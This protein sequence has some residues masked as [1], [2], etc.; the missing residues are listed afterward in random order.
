MT[1][2]LVVTNPSAGTADDDTVAAALD[3]LR[4]GADV[5]VEQSGSP[6]ELDDLLARRDGRT[7]VLLGG[8][9]SLHLAV[10]RLRARGEL[11]P[12]DPLGL[13]PLGTGNDLAR[14]LG[15]PLDP[16]AAAEVLLR[17]RPRTLDLIVDDADGAAVNAVHV[18]VGAEAAERATELKDRLG[19]AAYAVGS[20]AAGVRASGLDLT[21]EA[22]GAVV[23][24]G[25]PVLMVGVANGRSIGGGAELAPEAEPDDGWLD[26]VVA[27][28][29]G[30]LAR[31]GFGISLREGEHVERDDV[32][33]T[34]ARSV[35]V[36]GEAFPLNADGELEGP[37]SSRT[38]TIQPAAWSL[39]T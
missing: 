17:H 19:K 13:L 37:V 24:D 31:L 9:G 21:V 10:G 36:R 39:L 30:P 28:S 18:G 4:A 29:T 2:L 32:T 14:T 33:T 11:S 16:R 8:D 1:R 12:D 15:L 22:D 3:V 5:R 26:V 20:V 6:E 23:H 27:T 34:R 25:S 7:L 35:T 38:W